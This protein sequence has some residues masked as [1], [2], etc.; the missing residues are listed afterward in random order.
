MNMIVIIIIFFLFPYLFRFSTVIS[1]NTFQIAVFDRLDG[2]VPAIHMETD[3]RF[4]YWTIAIFHIF[5][6]F[7]NFSFQNLQKKGSK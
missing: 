4:I 6:Y 5:S 2:N 1:I 3:L 7:L